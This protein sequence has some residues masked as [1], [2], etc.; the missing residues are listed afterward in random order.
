MLIRI[1]EAVVALAIVAAL[2]A[3]AQAYKK[4]TLHVAVP[5]EVTLESE[6]VVAILDYAGFNEDAPLLGETI[7]NH[8]LQHAFARQANGDSDGP[9]VVLNEGKRRGGAYI[10][11]PTNNYTFIERSQLESALAE[12]SIAESGDYQEAQIVALAG[13]V[14]ADFVVYGSLHTDISD[15]KTT[16]TVT[17]RDKDTKKS[18]QVTVPCTKRTVSV[19]ATQRIMDVETGEILATRQDTQ[20]GFHQVC[21]GEDNVSLMTPSAIA[22][23]PAAALAQSFGSQFLCSTRG[24]EYEL[25]KIKTKEF[26]ELAEQA[27]SFADDYD[28]P[29]AYHIYRE[30]YEKDPYN[31]KI[32]Y[33]LGVMYNFSGHFE[34]AL[35]MYRMA[36][37]LRENGRYELAIR[38]CEAQLQLVRHLEELDLPFEPLNLESEALAEAALKVK[39]RGSHEDRRPILA[40]ASQGAETLVMI[41]GG[42]EIDLISWEGE[43]FQV[44]LLDGRNGFVHQ[45]FIDN[46]NAY[47]ANR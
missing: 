38:R 4:I 3:S 41:P 29:R 40:A 17:R 19:T 46:P 8:M 33:N 20:E 37:S 31:P 11:P 36:Q 35:E 25:D 43:W 42:I 39:I 1:R 45:E 12:L 23:I 14:G 26:K 7:T 24:Y 21:R 22:E 9:Q 32:L 16:K 30:L 13:M 44:R 27:A 10:T 18:Y 15:I 6:A 34:K 47:R 5:P 2:G 28:I